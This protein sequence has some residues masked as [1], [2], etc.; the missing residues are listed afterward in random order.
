[1]VTRTAGR[2]V[3]LEGIGHMPNLE[4]P[5]RFNQE[6]IAFLRQVASR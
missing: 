3:W 4:A 1:M 6:L 2:L 5:D